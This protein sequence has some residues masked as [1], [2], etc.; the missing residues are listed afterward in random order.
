[1]GVQ[2]YAWAFE[3][4]YNQ[5]VTKGYLDHNSN[6]TYSMPIT[7]FLPSVFILGNINNPDMNQ[8]TVNDM[9]QWSVT[10]FQVNGARE[11]SDD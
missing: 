1:M 5:Q 9:S 11:D 2:F 6:T 10:W 7:D 3:P 8:W 4:N